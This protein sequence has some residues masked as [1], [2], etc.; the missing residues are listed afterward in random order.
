M[1][2]VSEERRQRIVTIV[3]D[4]GEVTVSRLADDL[5]VAAETIRRDLQE[6]EDRRLIKRTHGGALPLESGSYESTLDY[7][8]VTRVP[9]KRR[10]ASAAVE[11]LGGAQT[12]FL[13]EGYTPLLIAEELTLL[14]DHLTIVTAS[15]A[16]A[17]ALASSPQHTTLLLGGRVR[18]RTLATVDH[19]ATDMLSVLN[20]DVAIL[21][22]NGITPD[23]GLG[24]PDPAVAAVKGMA[25]KRSTRR[26]FVGIATKFGV[27]SFCKF[28]DV[29]DL[30]LII[31]EEA[32]PQREAQRFAA[33]GPRVL[34]V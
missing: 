6:L 5:G 22:A 11:S 7:R 31:T 19:F 12:V 34:R 15:L 33:L 20:I 29:R 3:R 8:S 13:D 27:T 28:A 23:K 2:Q 18:D 16:N 30:E 9:E 4:D 1:G 24:T 26:I 10:I 14:H 25:V 21:G 17:M 32:L